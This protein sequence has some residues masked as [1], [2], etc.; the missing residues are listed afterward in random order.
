[1]ILQ[2][3][4]KSFSF[5]AGPPIEFAK[6]GADYFLS[7]VSEA[8]KKKFGWGY[9]A[10]LYAAGVIGLA[11]TESVSFAEA[12]AASTIVCAVIVAGVLIGEKFGEGF[13]VA[14]CLI[15]VPVAGL[16]ALKMLGS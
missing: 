13:G 5:H 14:V 15:G 10:F 4:R 3:R 2:C 7:A 16:A 9:L 1:M 11:S 6:S 8:N 12:T